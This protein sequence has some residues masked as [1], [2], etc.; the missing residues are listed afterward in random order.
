MSKDTA[1]SRL[2]SS[3]SARPISALRSLRRKFEEVSGEGMSRETS[4]RRVAAQTQHRCRGSQ[5]I[6]R[7]VRNPSAIQERAV[8]HR[9]NSRKL[10]SK[11]GTANVPTID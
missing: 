2:H 4:P 9:D 6:F 1:D 11:F 8:Q 10:N 7:Y 3:Q 5:P